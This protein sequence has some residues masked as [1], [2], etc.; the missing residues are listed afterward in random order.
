MT[1]H[2]FL[3][4]TLCH[5]PLLARVLEDAPSLTCAATLADHAVLRAT[6][7]VPLLM[8]VP[9]EQAQGLFLTTDAAGAA[10]L[11]LYR[12]PYADILQTVRVQTADGPVRAQTFLPAPDHP[13]PDGPWSLA[14]WVPREAAATI[15]AV[16][17]H[18]DVA[19]RFAPDLRHARH[20]MTLVR[21]DSS[22]RARATP[23][24]ATLRRAARREDL[25]IVQQR[26][27][28][29]HFFSV[30][31]ADLR[32]RR[33]DGSFSPQVTRAGFVMG[34]AVSVLPY[35]PATDRVMVVE[36]F[37]F[38]PHLRGD[39]NP[40]CLEPV[41]GRIDPGETPEGA[42]RREALEEADLHIDRLLPIARCYPSPGAIT[43][44]LCMFLGL[45]PLDPASEGIGGAASEA[46]DIRSHVLPFDR[47]MALIAGGEVEN[48]P[49]LTSAL[50]LAL[51]R[52]ELRASSER[53]RE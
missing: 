46:E 47:L 23:A 10:R 14:E 37:R 48:G 52:S 22:L 8:S 15:E 34:D 7:G 4:G 5:P 17:E 18:L 27:P 41:A 50:W 13:A 11:E 29:A 24:P 2:F 32:F 53:L 12:E 38:G 44:Y 21:A 39:P 6:A 26:R 42:A 45:T 1:G 36:Q 25:H 16:A 9:G 3:F 51:H 30:E 19:R 31:E 28:Y 40:W 43:E 35:D 33:F 49:L 20:A